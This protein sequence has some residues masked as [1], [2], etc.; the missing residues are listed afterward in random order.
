MWSRGGFA[1]MEY[2]ISYYGISV[3]LLVPWPLASEFKHSLLILWANRLF[4]QK[5]YLHSFINLVIWPDNGED[6]PGYSFKFVYLSRR[7][8]PCNHPIAEV[9]VFTFLSSLGWMVT[10]AVKEMF[11]LKMALQDNKIWRL[12]SLSSSRSK[13]PSQQ[14]KHQ[15]YVGQVRNQ[16]HLF[17]VVSMCW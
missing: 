5:L 4:K 10:T 6:F 14:S 17:L 7:L 8:F 3:I 2:V 12:L 11:A 1:S 13:L 15:K 16:S 9:I